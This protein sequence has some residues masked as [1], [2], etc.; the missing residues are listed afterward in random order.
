[1]TREELAAVQGAVPRSRWTVC[2]LTAPEGVIAERLRV[3]EP[4]VSQSFILEVSRALAAEMDQHHVAD[5]VVNNDDQPLT[6]VARDVL[7]R[8]RRSTVPS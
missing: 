8:W 1:M 6:A 3:R 2:R 7:T 5:F 4:G